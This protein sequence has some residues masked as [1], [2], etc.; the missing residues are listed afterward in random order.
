MARRPTSPDP[1]DHAHR[2]GL[3]PAEWKLGRVVT[4]KAASQRFEI[5]TEGERGAQN[6]ATA[7][8]ALALARR[9]S[10]LGRAVYVRDRSARRRYLNEADLIALA[11]EEAT[12]A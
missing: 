12:H 3:Y 9:S 11:Q 2:C 1:E 4:R 5:S 10:A 8:E 6:A 7:A